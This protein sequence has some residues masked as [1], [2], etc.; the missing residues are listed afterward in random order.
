MIN[1]EGHFCV[2]NNLTSAKSMSRDSQQ[3]LRLPVQT[4]ILYG[5]MDIEMVDK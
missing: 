3:R 5:E 2:Y 4:W 1:T